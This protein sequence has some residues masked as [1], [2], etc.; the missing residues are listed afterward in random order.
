MKAQYPNNPPENSIPAGIKVNDISNAINKSGY[1]LQLV[2]ANSL[3][4]ITTEWTTIQEE[5]AYVDSDTNQTRTLD[6]FANLPLYDLTSKGVRMRPWLTLL[7]ECKRTDLPYVFFLSRTSSRLRQFPIIGGSP[8]NDLC[9]LDSNQPETRT[10]A[11]DALGLQKHSFLKNIPRCMT[12][13]KCERK[14]KD[15]ILSGSDP[16]QNLVLPLVKAALYSRNRSRPRP[17]H[18]FFDFAITVPVAIIEGPMLGV[19]IAE[20]STDVTALPWIRVVRHIGQDQSHHQEAVTAIDVIHR[21]FWKQYLSDHLL[22]FA[23]D[24]S[25]KVVKYEDGIHA[26]YVQ[27]LVKRNRKG[28]QK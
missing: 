21:G 18:R 2:I 11:T 15:F 8:V 16:Y 4:E 10:N 9:W 1:P 19:Y 12:F 20:S 23:R 5:W 14:G 28:T 24:F 6:I 26:F 3:I 27:N 25:A 17:T 13:S 7:I 22:P